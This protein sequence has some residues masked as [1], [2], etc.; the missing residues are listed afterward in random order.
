M[1]ATA[2]GGRTALALRLGRLPQQVARRKL[3]SGAG[4]EQQVSMSR[5]LMAQYEAALEAQP[6]LTKSITSGTL[7]GIGDCVA[8]TLDQRRE[9]GAKGYDGARWLRAVAFGGLF[10]PI[11]AHI[12]YNFL[13]KLV[14][15]RWATPVSRVPFV[16]MFIEQ[17][18]YWS[19]LSNAYYHAVLGGLQGMSFTQIS[20]RVTSTL[21]DTLKA[22]WAFWIPAQLINFKYMP[23]RHQLNFVLVVS[24]FWTTFLSLAFPPEALDTADETRGEEKILKKKEAA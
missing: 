19:Y 3:S 1:R 23:V 24:L 2:F 9:G 14:V 22:Q 17:F 11:P 8:Q 4:S 5:R 6:L 20:D 12:H 10:Y 15:V 13:E 18:V 16:K 21:W 7:Y